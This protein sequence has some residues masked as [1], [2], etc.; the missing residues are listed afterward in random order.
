MLRLN[1]F[2]LYFVLVACSLVAIIW[3][4]VVRN[5]CKIKCWWY[6]FMGDPLGITNQNVGCRKLISYILP[7]TS[8]FTLVNSELRNFFEWPSDRVPSDYQGVTRSLVTGH[9]H[10]HIKFDVLYKF[11]MQKKFG[12]YENKLQLIIYTAYILLV[13]YHCYTL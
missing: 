5:L 10:F 1:Y 12:G 2:S 9:L 11:F 3:G 7:L 13:D 4:D 6:T 8:V